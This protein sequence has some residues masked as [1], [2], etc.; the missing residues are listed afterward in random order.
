MNSLTHSP[1]SPIGAVRSTVI[2]AAQLALRELELE[3][4]YLAN[5]PPAHHDTVLWLGV[6]EWLPLEL[7]VAHYQAYD[8]MGLDAAGMDAIAVRVAKRIHGTMLRTS[9]AIG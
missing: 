5:L 9:G 7:A 2:S 4:A 6:G 3:S 8:A 1:R